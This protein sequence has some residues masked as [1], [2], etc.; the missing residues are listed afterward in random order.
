[1]TGFMGIYANARCGSANVFIHVKKVYRLI[2]AVLMYA[3]LYLHKLYTYM[4]LI[5]RYIVIEI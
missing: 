2:Y 5:V 4:F 3:G 1:M